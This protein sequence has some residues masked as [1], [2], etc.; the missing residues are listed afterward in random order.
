MQL[1][2]LDPIEKLNLKLDTSLRLAFALAQKNSKT[3]FCEQND[4]SLGSTGAAVYA[5]AFNFKNSAQEFSLGEK[6]R[7]DIQ[8]I[9]A[10]HLRKD[11]PFDLSYLELLWKLEVIARKYPVKVWNNP[12]SV[13]A[14]NEKLTVMRFP[15]ETI[16]SFFPAESETQNIPFACEECVCKP[17][18]FHGGRGVEKRTMQPLKD[19]PVSQ[20]LQPF[21][22]QV[23]E[24]EVRAFCAFGEPLAWAL[25]KPKE[26]DFLANTA[27]GAT[28]H[29][30]EPSIEIKKRAAKVAETLWREDQ[31]AFVGFDIIGGL[32][33]EINLT[34][35]RLLQQNPDNME[36]YAKIATM[37]LSHL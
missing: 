20:L 32:I 27:R 18:N 33:S 34:S 22:K 29:S 3:L 8:K 5:R 35:P 28:L 21:L 26:G 23:H 4:F 2:I 12:R 16:P 24:G 6:Q 36:P 14:C 9:S 25:K 37:V 10:I 19:L 31:L 15:E 17:L 11:P 13:A 7:I 30:F 1:F